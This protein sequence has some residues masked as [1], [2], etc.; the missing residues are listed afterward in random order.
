MIL[1]IDIKNNKSR[2]HNTEYKT[3]GVQWFAKLWFSRQPFP[4]W[5]QTHPENPTVSYCQP[6][7]RMQ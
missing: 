7:C 6:M 4:R 2:P 3:V 5:I 1:N